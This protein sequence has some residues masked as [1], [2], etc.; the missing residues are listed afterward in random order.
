VRWGLAKKR[1]NPVLGAISDGSSAIGSVSPAVTETVSVTNPP[2]PPPTTPR[3][4]RPPPRPAGTTST[5]SEGPGHTVNPPNYFSQTPIKVQ[6]DRLACSVTTP[7]AGTIRMVGT[8]SYTARVKRGK[9]FRS[10]RRSAR[11]ALLTVNVPAGTSKLTVKVAPS[12]LA[13]LRRLSAQD[14]LKVAVRVAFTPT[15][16][17]PS[18][19]PATVLVHGLKNKP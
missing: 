14:G 13:Y 15:G 1:R 3:P 5:A 16:G 18:S 9:R 17:R 12:A 11:F 10:E 6:R 4:R 8:F 19:R 7:G 2:P